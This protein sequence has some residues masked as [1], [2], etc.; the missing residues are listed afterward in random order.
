MGTVEPATH[1]WY[2]PRWWELVPETLLVVGL[3]FFFLDD[4]DAATSAFRSARALTLM[5]AVA[6]AWIV[7]RLLLARFAP[8][9]GARVVPL[10][11]AAAT[12]LAIVVVPA[13]RTH[14]VVERLRADPIPFSDA[15]ND[16]G[17]Q[18]ASAGAPTAVVAPRSCSERAASRGSTIA[19]EAP[20]ASTSAPMA[21]TSSASRTSTSSPAP[22]TTCTSS[23][24]PIE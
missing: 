18:P 15:L 9:P 14:T 21:A 10:L 12:I 3:G 4:M 5:V 23:R 17:A 1:R 13:Y 20:S 2:R 6:V 16:T 11:A 19:P 24:A 8:W 7:V 22:T